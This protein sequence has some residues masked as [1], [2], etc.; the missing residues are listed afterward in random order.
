MDGLAIYLRH[1]VL[2]Y[3]TPPYDFGSY[4]TDRDHTYI[5]YKHDIFLGI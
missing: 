1:S 4:A 5:Q 3:E 2:N